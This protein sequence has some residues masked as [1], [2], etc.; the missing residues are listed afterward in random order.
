MYYSNCISCMYLKSFL[1]VFLLHPPQV[2]LR[3]LSWCMFPLNAGHETEE[4][5]RNDA[6]SYKV[7]SIANCC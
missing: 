2:L 4:D 5:R 6:F 3:Q 1:V 7:H